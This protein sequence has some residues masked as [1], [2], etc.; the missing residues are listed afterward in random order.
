MVFFYELGSFFVWV[1]GCGKVYFFDFFEGKNVFVCMV[2]IGF[3]KG[4]CLDNWDC[5]NYIIFLERWSEGLLVC[6]INVWYFSCWNLVNDIVVLFGEMRGYVFFSLDE[7][8]LVLFE[9]DE[10]YFIIWK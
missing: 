6:G 1:G 8:F 7:N 2:N 10:V 4:F 5:E 3:I 9:G